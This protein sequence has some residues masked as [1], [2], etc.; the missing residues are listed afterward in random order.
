M[1]EVGAPHVGSVAAARRAEEKYHKCQR[2]LMLYYVTVQSPMNQKHGPQHES[3]VGED[4]ILAASASLCV[5]REKVAPD[6][7]F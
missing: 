5:G 3:L 1:P 6:R 2:S 4:S 7:S